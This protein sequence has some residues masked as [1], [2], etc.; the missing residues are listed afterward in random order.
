MKDQSETVS[1]RHFALFVT[2]AVAI[3][4]GG[5]GVVLVQHLFTRMEPPYLVEDSTPASTSDPRLAEALIQLAKELRES[6]ASTAALDSPVPE[7][8]QRSVVSPSGESALAELAAAVRELRAALQ[9]SGGG[10]GSVS[11][12]AVTRPRNE[13]RTWLPELAADVPDHEAAYTRQHMFWTEQQ[14]VDKY[15]MP[16]SIDISENGSAIWSY[17]DPDE[18]KRSFY[19]RV[20]QG[21]V[22]S[23]RD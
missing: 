13:L 18:D 8:S 23:I 11:L 16:D 17:T 6:R 19:V 20:F 22:V 5:S 15:G 12:P 10:A 14:I 1:V 21:R 9:Q 7:P 4:A 3:F 2:I